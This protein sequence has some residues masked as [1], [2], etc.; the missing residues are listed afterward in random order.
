MSCFRDADVVLITDIYAAGEE[1]VPGISGQSLADQIR[2]LAPSTQE[3]VYVGNLDGADLA[4]R[5]RWRDGDLIL[6][7]GAGSITRLPERLTP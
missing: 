3:I 6:C 2:A 7:M 4:V 5:E 1:A